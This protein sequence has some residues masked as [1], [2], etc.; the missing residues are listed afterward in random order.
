[1][2]YNVS[3]EENKFPW[4]LDH[5]ESDK[6]MFVEIDETLSENITFGDMSKTPVRGKGKT[7]IRL[8][9]REHQFI[10]DVYYIWGMKTNI[11]SMGRLRKRLQDELGASDSILEECRTESNW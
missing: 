2:A 3:V 4:Q 10:Y 1:M 6:S 5:M 7:L 9:N 8:K 11:L